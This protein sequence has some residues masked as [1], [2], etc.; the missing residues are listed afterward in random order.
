MRRVTALN[1]HR[2]NNMAGSTVVPT[3]DSQRNQTS[4]LVAS[5]PS[6]VYEASRP[7]SATP[8]QPQSQSHQ[9]SVELDGQRSLWSRQ[10]SS[11]VDLEAQL[12]SQPRPPS[13]AL[14]AGGGSDH[15][16]ATDK[17][18]MCMVRLVW[19]LQHS[20]STCTI[21]FSFSYYL[22]TRS[23]FPDHYHYI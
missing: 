20:F 16:E 14:I 21:S 17:D 2:L 23:I 9:D 1:Q 5:L 7:P 19:Q 3:D 4:L 12:P 8:R 18:T 15:G 13:Q 10:S 6:I 11:S 22:C